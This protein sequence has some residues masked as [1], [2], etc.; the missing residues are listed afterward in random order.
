MET[1]VAYFD[2]TGD[3]GILQ[4]SSDFFVLT[5][6]YMPASSWQSNF[7]KIKA[8][9]KIL[10]DRYGLHVNEEIHTKNFLTDKN[11]YR[12]YPWS[13]DEKQEILKAIT[14]TISDLDLSIINVI[15]D[16][17]NVTKKESYH[18]LE[19][20]LKYN[21][22]RIDNDSKGKWNYIIITDKGRIASMRKT[23]RKIRAYNPIQ[24]KYSFAFKNQP[25]A[26]L[27]E[28]ILEKDSKES[29]FIQMADFISYFT[30]LHYKCRIKGFELPHRVGNIIDTRFIGSVMETLCVSQKFNVKANP[31]NRYGIVVYPK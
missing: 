10:K 21:I 19:N 6:V 18:V 4:T 1:Y 24:S 8:M 15:I 23:A 11:P 9:R 20:A 17:T 12:K 28:D 30:H 29:H 27:I 3:D 22:Q 2:E 7:N 25:I 16:K 26:G 5:S 14:L 31:A 13:K